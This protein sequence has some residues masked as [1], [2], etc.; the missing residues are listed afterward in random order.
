M[1]L[2]TMVEQWIA[3]E[4]ESTDTRRAY[5]VAMAGLVRFV[6]M[7]TRQSAKAL[8]YAD[9]TKAILTD[10]REELRS[11]YSRAT[12]ISRFGAIKSFCGWARDK[13]D[14]PNP[15]ILIRLPNV[16][17]GKMLGLTQ[18]EVTR[19]LEIAER[20][21]SPRN[22]FIIQLLILT[23]LRC[24]EARSLKIENISE[25]VTWINGVIGKGNKIRNIPI[26]RNLRKAIRC[27]MDF[28][29]C[30][31][32]TPE[33]P[34]LVGQTGQFLNRRTIYRIVSD[35]MV[36]SGIAEKLSHPHTLR[37]TFAREALKKMDEAGL[38]PAES[39]TKVRQLLGHSSINTT[40][41]YLNDDKQTLYQL[42]Q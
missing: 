13:Y 36:E 28:R 37:H 12:V 29:L 24:S 10:Y 39:L 7:K 27:Y 42:M 30:S 33:S 22:R 3:S 2:L 5:T 41:L 40:M 38:G 14:V 31:V 16:E 21:E 11:N 15:A 8:Q 17:P 20:L 35:I 19:L 6:S 9:V 25:D 4:F 32:H 18:A 1:P 34:L 23:G 26:S